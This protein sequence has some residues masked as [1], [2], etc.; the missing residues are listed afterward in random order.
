[1]PDD[2]RALHQTYLDKPSHDSL[3]AV[4]DALRP[5]IDYNL[6]SI[7]S[8]DDP[9]MRSKARVMTA[10]A[11]QSF[12]PEFGTSLPTWTSRQLMPL[13]RAR[14]QSQAVARV[15]E[16][17]QLDAFSLM[18]A[19][20]EFTDQHDREPDVA[21]LAD[22]SKIPIKRIA[23][24]RTSF[25]KMPS[26]AAVGDGADSILTDHSDEALDYVYHGA[27]A[28][29]RQIIERKMGYGGKFDPQ[30]PKDIAPALRLTPSQLSRRSANLAL[31]LQEI[32]S[33]LETV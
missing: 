1:V 11:V 7:R 28:I 29:D 32:R 25:R 20:K 24:I 17:I 14:R 10:K 6:S 23:K 4:V 19:E 31:Q 5:V 26:E 18:K 8:G 15:P 33:N 21:E 13:R 12:K 16:R 3:N 22:F 9:L 30:H 27:D 2:L